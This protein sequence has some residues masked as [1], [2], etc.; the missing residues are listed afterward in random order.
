MPGS[1]GYI[2]ICSLITVVTAVNTV[3]NVDEINSIHYAIDILNKPVVKDQGW[4]GEVMTVV[5]KH[6]QEYICSLPSVAPLDSDLKHDDD[7]FDQ[8]VDI[9]VL[10]K[11]ME[12][13]PCLIKTVDW[14][15]Y[16]FCYGS[17]IKQYHLEDNK[18]TGPIIILG[19]Y[20]SEYNWR[21]SSETKNRLQRFHSQFYVNGTKCDLTTEPRRTE[22]RNGC[23]QLGDDICVLAL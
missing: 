8:L 12:T 7:I 22:V 13:A 6:G 3:L 18:A 23:L 17:V 16:E 20:E 19:K 11:P 1:S 21:N 2:I 9:S 4:D 10:L 14:W 15:T 5:N